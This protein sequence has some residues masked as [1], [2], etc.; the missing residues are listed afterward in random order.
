[1]RM[2]FLDTNVSFVDSFLRGWALATSNFGMIARP[3]WDDKNYR[4]DLF[5]YKFGIT[6]KGPVIIQTMKFKDVCCVSVSEEEYNCAPSTAPVLR[7][8]QFIYN[9]YS[10][11]TIEGNSSGIK[12]NVKSSPITE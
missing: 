1:M 6:P 10:V 3:K 5:C 9:S 8:A 11:N 12:D 2:T 4:T 7:E